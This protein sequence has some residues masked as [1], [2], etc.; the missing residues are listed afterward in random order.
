MKLPTT[1]VET[2]EATEV[3]L[4]GATWTRCPAGRALVDPSSM[5]F[6][7]EPARARG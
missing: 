2:R 1:V 3:L 5:D 4:L 7:V 6:F